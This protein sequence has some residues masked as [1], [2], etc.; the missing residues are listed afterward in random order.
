MH[1][2]CDASRQRR[3]GYAPG[4]NTIKPGT[5]SDYAYRDFGNRRS[6]YL[7]VFRNAL[8]ELFEAFDFADPSL[9]VGRRN[10]S[11]VA[12]Q[13]LFLMNDPFVLEQSRAAAKR[14]L[15]DQSTDTTN[16]SNLAFRRTLGR[17]PTADRKRDRWQDRGRR[18][19]KLR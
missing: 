5:T 3:V 17:S 11:T 9:V 12:T 19:V 8:P 6:V 18:A 1:S 2:R 4:G 10:Q 14:T 15:A 16:G 7:P 13:A